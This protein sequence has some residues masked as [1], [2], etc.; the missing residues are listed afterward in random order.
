MDKI[1]ELPEDRVNYIISPDGK[2]LAL[3]GNERCQK[4]EAQ[5]AAWIGAN[6]GEYAFLTDEGIVLARVE[7][8][9]P[10]LDE[11]D[12]LGVFDN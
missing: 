1:L 10:E 2:I 8:E 9:A 11:E 5:L 12:L 6:N 7:E 3:R 4:T